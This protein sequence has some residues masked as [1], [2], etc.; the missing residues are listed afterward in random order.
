MGTWTAEEATRELLAVLPLLN[1]IVASDVRREVGEDTTM[2]QFRVLSYLADGPITLS[3]L[4]RRRR[5]SLQAMG[6]LAQV[7]VERGWVARLPDPSDRRQSLLQLTDHGRTHYER[8]SARMLTHLTPLLA[9]LTPEELGAV[10][11]ALGA[12]GRV[13]AGEEGQEEHGNR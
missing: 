2:P 3:A 8:A 4:A 9:A 13:L 5:V 11:V 1:R 10:R 12:L 6:E 7:L